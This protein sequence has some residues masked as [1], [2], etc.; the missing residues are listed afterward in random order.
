[1]TDEQMRKVFGF[2]NAEELAD[3]TPISRGDFKQVLETIDGN[4][5]RMLPVLESFD[6]RIKAIEERLERG[7]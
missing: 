1:M 3:M 6:A 7:Y 2:A 5:Q 4:F